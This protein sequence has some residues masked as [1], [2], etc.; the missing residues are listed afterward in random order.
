MFGF[1]AISLCS[2]MRSSHTPARSHQREACADLGGGELLGG[3]LSKSRHAR[4]SLIL[5]AT[6]ACVSSTIA[7][8]A[9]VANVTSL[10]LDTLSYAD[11][12]QAGAVGAGC[13]WLQAGDRAGRL[14]MADDRAAVRL[15]SSIVALKPALDAKP[16][17]LTYDRWTG[18]GMRL[19]VR[20][21]GKVVSR[22]RE[23]SRTIA[24]LELI[25]NGRA[26][27]WTGRLDCGS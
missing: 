10:P 1:A 11:A 24:L 6:L 20:D 13:T 19:R 15:G 26:R 22:G 27:V 25:M 5:S 23:R 3:T 9:G 8:G 21:S 17:F 14:S 12:E 7:A 18:G 4:R 2:R 16:L